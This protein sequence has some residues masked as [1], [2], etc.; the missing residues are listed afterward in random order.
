MFDIAIVLLLVIING[1]FSLSELAVVSA[2][3]PRLR[4]M[5]AEGRAGAA[6]AL[7]LAEDPGRF[8]STVQIG[9]T[10][11]GVLAGA[12]SGSALGGQLSALLLDAGVPLDVA[13]PLGFGVVVAL[14]TYL[15]IVV[16]ELVPKRL[17]LRNAETLACLVAPLMRLVS[18][19]AAPV[20]WLLD[21]STTAIFRLLGQGG[22]SEEKVTED[23]VHSL[24]A[25]AEQSGAIEESERE[26]ITGVLRL[27]DRPVRGIMTPRNDVDWIDLNAP[28][29][30]TYALLMRT[31]HSR[32]PVGEGSVETLLGVVQTRELLAAHL[33]GR[34]F[35]VRAAMRVA[36]VI[37]DAAD[38]LDALDVLRQA[39]VPMALVHDEYGHFEGIVT[40]AD[41][42]E[43][44]TGSFR[45]NEDADEPGA[46]ERDDGTWLLAGWL[47][48]D[49]MAARLN[50]RLPEVRSYHTVAGFVLAAFGRIPSV[51]ES[52]NILGFRFEVL[53]LDGRRIDK[54]LVAPAKA[55]PV[56]GRSG[57]G[58]L[59]QK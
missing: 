28:D 44:I 36:P 18:R 35:D 45:A 48:A 11:V 1:V 3:R 56:P 13:N 59:P 52:R 40:P 54:V 37:P 43:A 17:A 20:V 12:F 6:A 55:V 51:G 14:V 8:L 32:L 16:G 2:R 26:M 57:R 46:V 41:L 7:R 50:I 38:A 4:A 27:G 21:T 53:D 39:E 15:S 29:D 23:D 10:L 42:L 47:A 33:A 34:S 30:A 22:A 31:Q 25:E 24:V 9:I 5:A 58:T 19:I 49:D